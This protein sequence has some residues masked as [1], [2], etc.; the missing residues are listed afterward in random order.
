MQN[1]FWR[2]FYNFKKLKYIERKKE[3]RIKKEELKKKN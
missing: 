2:N 1:T 3:R